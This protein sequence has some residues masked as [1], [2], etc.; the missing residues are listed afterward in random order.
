[1]SVSFI[2]VF[3]LFVL[4]LGVLVYFVLRWGR[5]EDRRRN[6]GRKFGKDTLL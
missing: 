2:V 4:G 6:E 1:M 5:R 3:G